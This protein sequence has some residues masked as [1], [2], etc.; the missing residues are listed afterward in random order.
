L[1][2]KLVRLGKLLLKKLNHFL[3][4]RQLSKNNGSKLLSNS[5]LPLTKQNKNNSIAHYAPLL[6]L[7]IREREKG[8]TKIK[9]IQTVC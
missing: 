7:S 3:N 5:L 9:Y 2:K 6:K 1:N 8:K 4:S